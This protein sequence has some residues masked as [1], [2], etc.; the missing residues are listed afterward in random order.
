MSFIITAMRRVDMVVR[1]PKTDYSHVCSQCGAA[2]GLYPPTVKLLA[3]HPDTVLV[4]NRCDSR[5]T[6]GWFLVPKT[7]S[8]K[9][10]LLRGRGHRADV[11]SRRRLV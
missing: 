4:C 7:R 6:A 5:R 8:A 11:L 3:K 2:L 10:R 1:H 9:A